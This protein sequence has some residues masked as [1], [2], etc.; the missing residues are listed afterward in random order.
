V[1][2]LGI[3][4]IMYTARPTAITMPTCKKYKKLP[5]W[6]I[7]VLYNRLQYTSNGSTANNDDYIVYKYS[8]T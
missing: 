7:Q 1:G 2:Q 3:E 6:P 4:R 8:Y 5:R